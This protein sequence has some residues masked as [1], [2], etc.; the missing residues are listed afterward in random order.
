MH[1][2]RIS[3]CADVGCFHDGAGSMR[4]FACLRLIS[5]PARC[6]IDNTNRANICL[7]S[8]SQIPCVFSIWHGPNARA[9]R[10]GAAASVAR[11]SDKAGL[12]AHAYAREHMNKPQGVG[13]IV[14]KRR[15]MGWAAR[16]I[17][18]SG[19]PS[20]PIRS[21]AVLQT[22]NVHALEG[23]ACRK[24]V[25]PASSPT[26]PASRVRRLRFVCFTLAAAPGLLAHAL[27]TKQ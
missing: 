9:K 21:S 24:R 13:D 4:L 20:M 3:Y 1:P 7:R 14:C 16:L 26:A 10:T 17:C 18:C 25:A 15:R 5:T 6:N 23:L 27:V 11:Q 2:V 12:R 8:V 19:A 22:E